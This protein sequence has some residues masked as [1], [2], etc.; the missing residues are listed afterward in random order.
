MGGDLR[1]PWCLCR[2]LRQRRQRPQ[3]CCVGGNHENRF[4]LR[5][6]PCRV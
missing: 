4:S 3:L 1:P 2:E 5:H 6:R